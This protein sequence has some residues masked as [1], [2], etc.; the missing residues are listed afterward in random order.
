[1]T[2]MLAPAVATQAAVVADV[3]QLMEAAG[4]QELLCLTKARI[5]V[6][7]FEYRHPVGAIKVCTVQTCAARDPH[8]LCSRIRVAHVPSARPSVGRPSILLS[9]IDCAC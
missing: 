2:F 3:A 5:P 9:Y 1:M 8:Q 4:M 6:V 7:K